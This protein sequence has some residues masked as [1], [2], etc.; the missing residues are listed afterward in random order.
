MTFFSKSCCDIINIQMSNIGEN[1]FLLID[2]LLAL[3]LSICTCY[4]NNLLRLE[5]CYFVILIFLAY[6]ILLCILTLGLFF[7]LAI[8]LKKKEEFAKKQNKYA[9]FM[10]DNGLIFIRQI[11][12]VRFKLEGKEL[13]PRNEKLLIVSNHCSKVDPMLIISRLKGYNVSWIAKKSIY[14][15]PLINRYMHNS[16]FL[17]LDRDDVRQG[18]KVINQASEYIKNNQNSIGIFP[19]GTRNTADKLL[20]FKAGSFKIAKKTNCPIAITC[21]NNTNNIGKRWPIPTKVQIKICKVIYK[22]DY[23]NMSTD[24]LAKYCSSVVQENLDEMRKK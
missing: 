20:D 6:F 8:P 5:V 13:L 4:F 1:M 17:A 21:I 24:E 10:L 9:R 12:L 11:M 18:L 22:E 14:R 23:E 7:I 3:G 15:I 19:E 2:I 16:C